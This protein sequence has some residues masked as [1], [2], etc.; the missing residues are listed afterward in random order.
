C[1]S[2]P[3]PFSVFARWRIR[4]ERAALAAA[5]HDRRWP[6][7]WL[8]RLATP[9][10]IRQDRC[11]FFTVTDGGSFLQIFLREPVGVHTKRRRFLLVRRL[12]VF[13]RRF[14]PRCR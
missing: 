11:G 7:R 12:T 5:E 1:L 3:V 4:H 14:S 2:L 10:V 6:V 13:R 8:C 9:P